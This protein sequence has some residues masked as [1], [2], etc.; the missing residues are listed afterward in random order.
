MLKASSSHARKLTDS[1]IV[2]VMISF[3]ANMPQVT[4]FTPSSSEEE[5]LPAASPAKYVISEFALRIGSKVAQEADGI[6]NSTNGYA[7]SVI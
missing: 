3:P 4:G 5:K 1:I 7:Q 6:K 2:G